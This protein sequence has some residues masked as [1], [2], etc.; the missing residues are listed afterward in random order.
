M[1]LP[2]LIAIICVVS[3]AGSAFAQFS[4]FTY[5]AHTVGPVSRSGAVT[6]GTLTWSC[7]GSDCTIRGPWLAPGVPACAS[8]AAQV[9][10]IASYGR[11]GAM[12]TP[13]QLTQCNAG[14][15]VVQF[16]PNL[17][18]PIQRPLPAPR[19]I[20]PGGASAATMQVGAAIQPGFGA[21]TR[22]ITSSGLNWSC[23]GANCGSDVPPGA[24]LSAACSALRAAVSA[25][26]APQTIFDFTRSDGRSLT[27]SQLDACNGV[28]P[29]AP[30]PVSTR[31]MLE[32]GSR[33]VDMTE[34]VL[35]LS[36]LSY[37]GVS[38]PPPA[39]AM[40]SVS[41]IIS[42]RIDTPGLTLRASAPGATRATS[43]LPSAPAFTVAGGGDVTLRVP[44][45]FDDMPAAT[46]G[47]RLDCFLFLTRW[48]PNTATGVDPRYAAISTDGSGAQQALVAR[49]GVRIYIP[50]NGHFAT[51]LDIPLALQPFFHLADVRSY[52][53]DVYLLQF[54]FG[55]VH[56][57]LADGGTLE[58]LAGPAS[59]SPEY[60]AA[61]GTSPQLIIAGNIQ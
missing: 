30:S 36:G 41:H 34:H 42:G 9:G 5:T 8:L 18:R 58:E 28:L 21:S 4:L 12:L 16:N 56:D 37:T 19:P 6:A 45:A 35:L 25:G 46:A 26:G 27:T 54:R 48:A 59:A 10:P 31:V 13:A 29:S 39:P 40:P 7:S 38:A 51:T 15:P 17:N 23:T 43:P 11:P 2:H 53:C 32:P 3:F 1:R 22:T 55:D 47:L 52:S 14:A 24:D 44:I 60:H 33:A 49:G 50:S 20:S 61:A 57:P